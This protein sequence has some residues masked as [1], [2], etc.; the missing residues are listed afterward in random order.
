MNTEGTLYIGG[1]WRRS[2][3]RFAVLD[4]ATGEHLGWADEARDTDA[5]EALAAAESVAP[6]WRQTPPEKRG[7]I[8]RLVARAIRDQMADLARLLTREN[9]KPIP[10]AER[11]LHTCARTLEWCAEEARRVYGRIVALDQG[12]RGAV[13]REPVGIVVAISPWN[14]PASMLVRKI[15]LALAAGCPVITKPAEQTPLIATTMTRLF[16]EAG[17]P[18]GVLNQLT[19]QR[20]GPLVERLLAD[21]RVAKVSFTGSTEVGRLL[22]RHGG[23]RIKSISLELGGHAPGIVFPDADLAATVDAVVAAK[24]ANAGQSCIALNR[25]YVHHTVA[26]EVT[27]RLVERV[28]K[29]TVGPG[30]EPGTQVGPLIDAAALEKLGQQVDEAVAQGAVVLTGGK[31]LRDPPYDR[32]CF[33]A[34]TVMT[35][36]PAKARMSCEEIF[37]PVLPVFEFT[38]NSEVVV[39]ANDTDYGLAAYLFGRDLGLLWEIAEQ[40]ECGVVGVNNPFPV[41]PELPFGGVKNSG[42][43]REGGSEGIEAYLRTKSVALAMARS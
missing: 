18:P 28:S 39:R 31:P 34:P 32:G 9:G 4:P 26:A 5:M 41:S 30:L 14:F 2:E 16:A 11:E 19:T 37:G 35:G 12:R 25:L 21:N 27:E 33:F 24:F 8:L 43:G 36:M 29:L 3:D 40:L 23:G 10:E 22:L 17:C 15:G 38:D 13:L 20:P 1:Q 42:L 6:S 7:E